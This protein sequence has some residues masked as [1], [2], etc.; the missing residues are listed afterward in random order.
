MTQIFFVLLVIANYIAE[1]TGM[2]LKSAAVEV[3]TTRGP[4]I[5]NETI[6]RMA[7][8]PDTL[9]RKLCDFSTWSAWISPGAKFISSDG[10]TT[11]NS[12]DQSVTERFGLFGSSQ[13]V[14][15]TSDISPS[16]LQVYSSSSRGTFGWDSLE[17]EFSITED[18][19]AGLGCVLS[20]KYSWTV[21]NPAVAVIERAVIRKS[22]MSDNVVA[23]YKL[24]EIITDEH[25]IPFYCSDPDHCINIFDY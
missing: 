21:P 1:C 12:K 5:T 20:F 15:T 17:M 2:L 13:I 19:S 16:K 9:Y 10:A 24:N 3:Q 8:A 23:L 4:R 14:W 7:C 11:F 6:K 25:D 22:M 18:K